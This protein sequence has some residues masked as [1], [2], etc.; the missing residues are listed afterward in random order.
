MIAV[1]NFPLSIFIWIEFCINK[2]TKAIVWQHVNQFIIRRG[3]NLFEIE[4]QSKSV[5]NRM[6]LNFLAPF[7]YRNW[8]RFC[9]RW[10]LILQLNW[11]ER[12]FP[13]PLPR[14]DH[15]WID[16]SC[17]LFLVAVIYSQSKCGKETGKKR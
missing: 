12:K 7:S 1:Y 16:F 6:V 2:S 14:F 8:S 13:I 15:Y 3:D 4:M 11:I 5:T 9:Q 10:Q 17:Y